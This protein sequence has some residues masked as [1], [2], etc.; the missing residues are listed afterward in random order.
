MRRPGDIKNLP[1]R[2]VKMMRK[3]RME[4]RTTVRMLMETRPGEVAPRPR[5]ARRP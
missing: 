1:P 5:L 3:R 4:P 2:M